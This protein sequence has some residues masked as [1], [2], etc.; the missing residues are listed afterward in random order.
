M[1][2]A[3]RR[4][5]KA[6][7]LVWYG[8]MVTLGRGQH[9]RVYRLLGREDEAGSGGGGGTVTPVDGCEILD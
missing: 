1:L 3:K 2:Y 5:G 7:F 8:R 4:L 9:V 6:T